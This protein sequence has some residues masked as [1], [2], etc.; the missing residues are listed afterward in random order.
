MRSDPNRIWNTNQIK[1]EGNLVQGRQMENVSPLQDGNSNRDIQNPMDPQNILRRNRESEEGC[2]QK[3]NGKIGDMMGPSIKSW[4]NKYISLD[5]IEAS[6]GALQIA[7]ATENIE[8][9]IP[10]LKKVIHKPTG[11]VGY[12]KVGWTKK[13]SHHEEEK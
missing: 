11:Q 6:G 1:Q 5:R 10:V 9:K 4:A 3:E 8:G 2:R 13:K 7:N 12:I